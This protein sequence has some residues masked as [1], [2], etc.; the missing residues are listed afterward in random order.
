M[1]SR[2]MLRTGAGVLLALL[3]IVGQPSAWSQT[4]TTFDP[5]GSLG[6]TP[7]SINPAGEIVGN[8]FDAITN[9]GF[10]RDTDGAIT[11]L[12]A[13]GAAPG[14]AFPNGTFASLIT[15]QGL[16]AGTYF[17]ANFMSHIFL[18]AKDGTFATLAVPNAAGFTGGLVSN[19]EGA[20]AGG[21]FDANFNS[22]GFLRAPNGK[23]TVFD[24]PPNFFLT[25]MTA[26]G[27]ILGSTLDTNLATHGF[28]RAA[29]GTI[30]T[31][32]APNASPGF[33]TGT[34]PTSINNSG[35]ATGWYF[36]NTTGEIQYFLRA[37]DGTFSAFTPPPPPGSFGNPAAINSSGTIVGSVQVQGN[38]A[39]PVSFLRTSTGTVSAI[40]DPE[41]VQ[42]T[43]AIAINPAGVI[44]GQSFDANGQGHGFVRKPK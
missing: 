4:F 5:P 6:T 16:I 36:D 7:S 32:D 9:H 35:V 38:T 27:A 2:T 41:G 17:D 39:P 18:R 30:T 40:S 44:T 23:I 43:V 28:L 42:G 34:S 26:S 19:T 8:Y 14:P 15:P 1:K 13:P 3:A 22:F 21:F 24:L 12:D 10:L 29:N 37:A 25:G 20:I 33:F 11:T 31:F